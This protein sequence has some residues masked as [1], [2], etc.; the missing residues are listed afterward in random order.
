MTAEYVSEPGTVDRSIWRVHGEPL[1]AGAA[2]GPLAGRRVAVKDLLAVAGHPV[3]LG[4]PAYLAE[5]AP[6]PVHA[7]AVQALLDAG[8]SLAGIAQTDEFA[9]SIAG[10]NSH[11]GTP[12]NGASP[13]RIP[14]GSSS[15]PASAVALGQAEI[16]LGTDT[17]G[18]VR[19]PASYQGLWGLRPTHGAVSDAGLRPL[20]PSFDTPGWLTRDAATLRLAAEA[21]LPESL[22]RSVETTRVLV[23]PSLLAVADPAL[24][25]QF[26]AVLARLADAGLLAAP[27]EVVLPAPAELLPVFR[28]VQQAEAWASDGAWVSAHWDSLGADIR[29]RFELAAEVGPEQAAAGR[30]ALAAMR[31][32]LDA[33]LG[34]ALLLLP[35]TPGPAPLLT[36]G[37]EELE[38]VRAATLGT[39]AVA[40]ILGAP[41]LSV[42]LLGGPGA[43]VGLCLVGPGHSDLALIELG[44]SLAEALAG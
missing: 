44:A 13:E 38:S 17:A 1:V 27:E 11:Y 32:R 29:T 35:S 30:A 7:A 16:G 24:R 41:A 34:G 5:Q 40:G 3:G 42:P 37:G 8:A 4:S 19:V 28:T 26:A 2:E 21:T 20:A 18:S 39:T 22:Q 23:A 33:A 9:Y 10:R 14:G 6:E 25:E 31:D 15:G 12:P 36:A 43:P